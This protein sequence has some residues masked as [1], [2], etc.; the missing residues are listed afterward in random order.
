MENLT[1]E[2]ICNLIPYETLVFN[3]N[4]HSDYTGIKYAKLNG[5]YPLYKDGEPSWHYTTDSNSTGASLK[6]CK[7]I[8]I[9]PYGLSF[10][11]LNGLYLEEH[12]DKSEISEWSYI[13]DRI[14]VKW[15]EV[16]S[17]PII[18][19]SRLA[20]K[21]ITTVINSLGIERIRIARKLHIDLDDLITKSL[22]ID[23]NDLSEFQDFREFYRKTYNR[24]DFKDL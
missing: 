6:D 1:I 10:N 9:S 17:A 4:H 14:Q 5:C 8:L 24:K 21:V 16:T 23:L 7:P 19:D 12:L 2:H 18:V 11:N 20:I 22:A 3:K 13:Y 15:K